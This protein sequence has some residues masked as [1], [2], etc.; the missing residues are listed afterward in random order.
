MT[1]R[2]RESAYRSTVRPRLATANAHACCSSDGLPYYPHAPHRQ[3]Q[4]ATVG[5]RIGSAFCAVSWSCEC[6]TSCGV[7]VVSHRAAQ[8]SVRPR[9]VAVNSRIGPGRID[10]ATGLTH[11]VPTPVPETSAPRWY[12]YSVA[13]CMAGALMWYGTQLL[14]QADSVELKLAV[15]E[16]FCATLHAATYP[17]P[18]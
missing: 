15:H 12:H 13:A 18:N 6:R 11:I 3:I 17:F 1:E 2:R 8:V 5:G 14:H 9:L 7:C 16:L 10:L 4:A